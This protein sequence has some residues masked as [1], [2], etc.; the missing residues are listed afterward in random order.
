[1]D[2][3]GKPYR[4]TPVED[5][6]DFLMT[7]KGDREGAVK[8]AAITGVRDK[9]D[10]ST[11][12]IAYR[13]NDEGVN[14]RWEVESVCS[15]PGC[16]VRHCDA[17]PGTRYVQLAESFGLGEHGYVD[18]VCQESFI[19]TMRLLATFIRCPDSFGLTEPILDPDLVNVLINGE[20]VPRYSC[21][22]EAA[23]EACGGP[24]DDTCSVGG[25]VETWSYL[26]PADPPEAFA[27][28]GT[29]RFA[30]HYRPCDLFPEGTEV[31][32]EVVYITP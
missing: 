6:H 27:R 10:L 7:L 22:N 14:P 11:T 23:L 21:Q 9:D 3:D 5:Y 2:P 13:W 29:I 24:Q 32:I 4:L 17:K 18:T 8:F 12:D 25:C 30:G 28:G 1:M 15:T 19:E 16:D 26:P 20:P 31:H